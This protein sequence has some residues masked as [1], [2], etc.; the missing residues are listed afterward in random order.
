M[1]ALPALIFR[2]VTARD[3][4]EVIDPPY[5]AA[6]LG[7][8]LLS[9]G[10]GYGLSRRAGLDGRRARSRQWACPAPTAGSWAIR[11]C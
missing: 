11:S 5:L 2:A 9:L 4:A 10:L 6:Y 1:L 7:G 3:L 8:S